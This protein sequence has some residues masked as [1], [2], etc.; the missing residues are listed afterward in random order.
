MMQLRSL[1][2]LYERLVI[3]FTSA[4]RCC[5]NQCDIAYH[6]ALIV[7]S[8]IS[9]LTFIPFLLITVVVV[10][11]GIVFIS[12][13]IYQSCFSMTSKKWC[14]FNTFLFV[15]WLVTFFIDITF[16]FSYLPSPTP[17]LENNRLLKIS[18][19]VRRPWVVYLSLSMTT[20]VSKAQ[21]KREYRWLISKVDVASIKRREKVEVTSGFGINDH[22][23]RSCNKQ[24]S[25]EMMSS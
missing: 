5:G 25:Y 7:L 24:S 1:C 8:T 4:M 21:H 16:W 3:L 22:T 10:I 9:S 11:A 17:F 14:H 2:T 6:Y 23:T 20:I 13:F 12:R 19:I 15:F 18:T